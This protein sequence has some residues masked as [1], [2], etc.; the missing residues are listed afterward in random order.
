MKM[1]VKTGI[2]NKENATLKR[3]VVSKR[4]KGITVKTSIKAGLKR[5]SQFTETAAAS[6]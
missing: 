1:Q 5:N 2:N 4:R 3:G 6:G